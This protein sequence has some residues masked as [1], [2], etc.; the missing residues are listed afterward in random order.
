[1]LEFLKL[2][3]ALPKLFLKLNIRLNL[4]LNHIENTNFHLITEVKAYWAWS[5]LDG[6][7]FE[8]TSTVSN[9]IVTP[10]PHSNTQPTFGMWRDG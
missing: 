5:V 9:D 2:N 1:M 6:G 7:P 4:W 8:N 3:Y 10:P